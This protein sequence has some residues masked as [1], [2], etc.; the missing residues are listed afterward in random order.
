MNKAIWIGSTA[1]I[2]LAAI[3]IWKLD[4]QI[5]SAS[6]PTSTFPL[7]KPITTAN[8]ADGSQVQI[9][10]IGEGKIEDGQTTQP[11]S[12]TWSSSSWGSHTRGFGT[13]DIDRHWFTRDNEPAGL[14]FDAPYPYLI[15]ETRHLL[16]NGRILPIQR[17]HLRG[18]VRE[19]GNPSPFLGSAAMLD[20]MTDSATLPDF[21]VQLAD[22]HGGWING[23]GPLA[24]DDDKEARAAI[25]F[26][27]WPRERPTL[28]FRVLKPGQPAVEVQLPNLP[29][30]PKPAWKT[31]PLPV[32]RETPEFKVTIDGFYFQP[33]KELTPL[34][35]VKN[36]FT[37]KLPNDQGNEQLSF[38]LLSLEDDTGNHAPD[39]DYYLDSEHVVSGFPWSMDSTQ[40]RVHGRITPTDSYSIPVS[41]C[42]ILLEG[43]V[44]KDGKSFIPDGSFRRRLGVDKIDL[45]IATKEGHSNVEFKLEGDFTNVELPAIEAL[46]GKMNSW[47]PVIFLDHA[48][49][50]SGKAQ[51]NGM[52]NSSTGGNYHFAKEG[53]WTGGLKP[54]QHVSLGVTSPIAPTDVQFTFDRAQ[55]R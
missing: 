43:T 30:K 34:L 32:M 10:Q 3:V 47:R 25:W 28:T 55:I 53:E 24:D 41:R 40:V 36:R 50:S 14:C 11:P 12:K 1:V 38:E 13:D 52:S 49:M 19:D 44:S 51:F 21:L 7:R 33:R 2:L 31:D 16:A 17:T 29:A 22:G 20:A 27:T 5:H 35:G 46:H 45:T 48:D 26:R 6:S 39:E 18:E 8:F 42:T 9:L 15:L 23:S 4:P 54:G 37:S